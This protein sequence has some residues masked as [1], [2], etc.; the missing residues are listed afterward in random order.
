M[1]SAASILVVE[2]NDDLAFGLQTNLEVQGY[3]VTLA[4]DGAEGLKK[5]LN[6]GPDM[7]ILDIMLPELNGFDMLRRFRRSDKITPVLLLTAK[8]NE[9]D[10]VSGLRLGADD[11][12]TKPF[13]LMELMARVEALLRR[14]GIRSAAE[15]T[16]Y[17]FGDVQVNAETRQVLRDGQ[18]VDLTPKELGLLIALLQREG[19]IAS[20]IELMK[21]V[22]GHASAVI[23]RTVDT[24][25]AELRRKLEADPA[26]P[27]YIL[28]VR[29]A[30]YRLIRSDSRSVVES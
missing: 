9:V 24:H 6:D 19:A 15:A 3:R 27:T 10:K 18:A 22:W 2:D 21:E 7:I 4:S 14:A 8:G 30:G 5:A 20:R 17:E 12:V 25:I 1:T 13:A 16:V 23:S 11:Y 26:H 29:K 28:T